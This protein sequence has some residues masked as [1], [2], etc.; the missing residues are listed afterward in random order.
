L[1]EKY[2]KDGLIAISVSLDFPTTKDKE[3]V[4]KFLTKSQASFTNLLLDESQEFWQQKFG[5][6][7]PPCVFVFNREGKWTRFI[8]EKTQPAEDVYPRVEKLVTKLL[9]TR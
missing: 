3:N 9:G 8:D 1:H 6:N 4:L 2:G 7:G 5:F